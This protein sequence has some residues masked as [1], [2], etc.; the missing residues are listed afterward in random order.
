MKKVERWK[1]EM[2]TEQEMLPKDKYTVFDRKVK[3]YRKGIHST[4]FPGDENIWLGGGTWLLMC[5]QKY[6]SGRGSVRDS[7]RLVSRGEGRGECVYYL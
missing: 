7:I 4:F 5:G 1:M 3:R 2:P 6:Q